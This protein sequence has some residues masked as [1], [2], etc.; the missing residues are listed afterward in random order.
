MSVTH[1]Y[2]HHRPLHAINSAPRMAVVGTTDSHPVINL[3]LLP[4][5]CLSFC[6]PS[7]TCSP[8]AS[9]CTECLLSKG[10]AAFSVLYVSPETLPLHWNFQSVALT[11]PGAVFSRG[12][13]QVQQEA[14]ITPAKDSFWSTVL[15]SMVCSS[16]EADPFG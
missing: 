5:N 15:L 4:S 11:P 10:F 12:C 3:L 1:T 2:T 6:I 7:R 9:F 14:G 13:C 16:L 8:Q